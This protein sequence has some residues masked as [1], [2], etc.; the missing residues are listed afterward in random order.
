MAYYNNPGQVNDEAISIAGGKTFQVIQLADS[1]GN[2]INPAAG[3][4][5]LNGDVV[6]GTEIEISNDVGN[7]V[8][9]QSDALGEPDDSVATTDTG[10]FS[11]L[12]L[13]KRALQGI[14]SI[15]GY[16]DGVEGSLTSVDGKLPTLSSGRIPIDGSGVTQPVSAASL[17]LPSGASTAANQ[18]TIIGHIDGVEGLLTTIDTDTS[19]IDGKLPALSNGRIPVDIGAI[20]LGDVEIKNDVGNPIPTSVP[21]RTPTT[22]SVASSATSVTILAANA[23]RRGISIANDSTSILRLS[24][25]TPATAANSFIV[26]QPQSFLF[27]DQ[28]LMVGNAVYGIWASANGTAQVTEYV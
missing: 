22:T 8:P 15:V 28:Q 9:V 17:P 11:L 27:L 20:S 3:D 13:V 16:V 2:I 7:P 18:S 19:S 5:V 1:E 6:I 24:F 14:T 4:I 21:L 12:A 25:S 26:M 10:T 23:V